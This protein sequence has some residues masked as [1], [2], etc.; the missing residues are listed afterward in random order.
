MR[1]ILLAVPVIQLMVFG[2]ALR[3]EVRNIRLAVVAAPADS[4][5]WELGR[6][7][8]GGGWFTLVEANGREPIALLRDGTA[9]AV[10]V[11][12]PGGF[13]LAAT[14]GHGH[15]Q[16]L[17]DASNSVRAEGVASYFEQIR[18]RVQTERLGSGGEAVEGVKLTTR[19]LYN[20]TLESRLFMVPGVLGMLLSL[21]ALMLTATSITKEKE[22]GTFETLLASPITTAE[23][24]LGKALPYLMLTTL[25][26][27][28]LVITVAHFVF[29]VPLKGELWKLGLAVLAFNAT[30][31]ALGVL[32]STYARNQQ[33]AMLGA[34][35]FI[36]PALMLSGILYPLDNMPGWLHWVTYLNPLRYFTV[37]IRNILLKGGAATLFWPNLSALALL[38]GLMMAM[39]WRKFSPTLNG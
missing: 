16:L 32:I 15:G 20:P 30:N 13:S 23:I 6:R 14:R 7:A 25:V 28:P 8:Q 17:L 4:L 21:L 36:Y 39:A 9:D 38:G 34:F 5:A 12:P 1:L 31:V 37:L 26:Q 22:N 3:T 11:A 35:L 27:A 24:L 2:L 18:R 19:V 29:Q 33:Q 10:L